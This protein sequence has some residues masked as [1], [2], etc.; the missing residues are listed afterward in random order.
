[1]TSYLMFL[2]NY[3]LSVLLIFQP[4]EGTVLFITSKYCLLF[5]INRFQMS[6]DRYSLWL[7]RQRQIK[8]ENTK[9]FLQ[10]T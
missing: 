2:D 8:W 3:F 9:H 1:M 6:V 7:C 5:C 10:S 4:K